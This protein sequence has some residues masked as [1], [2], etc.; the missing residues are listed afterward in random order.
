MP[1]PYSWQKNE[2]GSIVDPTTSPY[3]PDVLSLYNKMRVFKVCQVEGRPYA[4]RR[5]CREIPKKYKRQYTIPEADLIELLAI[6]EDTLPDGKR[7]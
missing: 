2:A 5:P 3:G 1:L 6:C 7:M 4:D